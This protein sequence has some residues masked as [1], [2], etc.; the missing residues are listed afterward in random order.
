MRTLR[1]TVLYGNSVFLAGLALNCSNRPGLET[2]TIDTDD[3]DAEQQL[4]ALSPDVIVFDLA[5]QPES[6]VR[7]LKECPDL[8]LIGV[9]ATSNKL[10]V[11]SGYRSSVLTMDDLVHVIDRE[12]GDSKQ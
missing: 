2:A 5:A 10:I 4:R 7:L 6:A 1:R 12:M 11:L 8:R 9:D 3:P